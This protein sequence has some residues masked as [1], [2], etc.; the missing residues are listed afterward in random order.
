[1]PGNIRESKPA[2]RQN[3][4]QRCLKN[5]AIGPGGGDDVPLA[6]LRI[7]D[8][9]E[10]LIAV[11]RE[12]DVVVLDDDLVILMGQDVGDFL[13]HRSEPRRLTKKS[14]LAP[15]PPGMRLPSLTAVL[16]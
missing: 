1:M 2:R 4:L 6:L 10:V 13:R 11:R 16:G 3:R 7:V 9:G 5:P 8:A 12:G 15:A 14:S